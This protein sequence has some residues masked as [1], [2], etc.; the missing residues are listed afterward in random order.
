MKLRKTLTGSLG[1]KRSV[2]KIASGDLTKKKGRRPIKEEE[3]IETPPTAS[4]S[5]GAKRFTS[6]VTHRKERLQR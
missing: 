4:F 5:R 2:F 6:L 1:R 3:I